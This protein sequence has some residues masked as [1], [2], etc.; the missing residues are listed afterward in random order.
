M[1]TVTND[2]YENKVLY[3]IKQFPTPSKTKPNLSEGSWYLI[4]YPFIYIY[5]Y[6]RVHKYL[7]INIV[8]RIHENKFNN[9][10]LED[11]TLDAFIIFL[12]V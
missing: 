2:N 9:M 4:I 11:E 7:H 3:L 5:M 8:F 10:Y 12:Q 1:K 6:L